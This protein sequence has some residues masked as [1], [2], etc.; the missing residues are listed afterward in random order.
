MRRATIA[1]PACRTQYVGLAA[2]LSQRW[3]LGMSLVDRILDAIREQLG[4]P[5][6]QGAKTYGDPGK[7]LTHRDRDYEAANLDIAADLEAV[8][9]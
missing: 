5:P 8:M 2:R 6:R 4:R 1:M 3:D 7:R 9:N